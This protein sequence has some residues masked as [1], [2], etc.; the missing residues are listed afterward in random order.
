MEQ[1]LQVEERRAES[2]LDDDA[3]LDL[4]SSL[5]DTNREESLKYWIS[6]TARMLK[7]MK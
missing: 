6:L 4:F 5:D 1:F 3:G 7:L 2:E